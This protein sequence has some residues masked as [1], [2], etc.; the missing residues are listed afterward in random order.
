[1]WARVTFVAP[2]RPRLLAL[3]AG[4]VLCGALVSAALAASL[5]F[6]EPASSPEP[7]GGDPPFSMVAADFDGD[8][9]QDL[10]TG[11]FFYGD[12]NMT[13]LLNNGVGNFSEPRPVPWRDPVI[14]AAD[15][16]GDG[17][18][19]L[20]LGSGSSCCGWTVTILKN[21]GTGRFVEAASS[22]ETIEPRG[23]AVRDLVAVD[24][25][26]DLD[27]D[28]AVS[29]QGAR[30]RGYGKILFNDGTGDFN[31]SEFGPWRAGDQPFRI[32]VGDIDLDGD[33]DLAV[34][35]VESDN[36]TVLRNTGA[37]EFEEP[38]SSPEAVGSDPRDIAL[39][40]VDGDGDLDL[41]VANAGDDNVSILKRRGNVNFFEAPSSPEP[42]GD[43]PRGVVAGDFDADGDQD[44]A[45]ANY[46][47]HNVSILRNANAG[48]FVEVPSSPETVGTYPIDLETRDLDGDG[49]PDLAVLNAGS[50]DVTILRNP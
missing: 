48:N 35:N 24:V 4:V 9:D 43:F 17:D 49:D 23:N 44:L 30:P 50:D 29:Q 46:L 36:V 7:V 39:P 12:G 40:D 3:V 16:D 37:G 8:G 38:P 2:S 22:P 6:V 32:A 28:L 5:D 13:L 20:A 27:Q 14:A 19:D 41:V 33:Q 31:L 18:Q 10:V 45:V 47:S 11:H 1:M 34:T 26:G 21:T 15:L 25:D 42:V